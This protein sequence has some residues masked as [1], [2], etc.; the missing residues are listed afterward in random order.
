MKKVLIITYDFPPVGGI[1]SVYILRYVKLLPKLGWI[2]Y[3]LTTSVENRPCKV[4]DHSLLAKVP[5]EVHITRTNCTFFY[6]LFKKP[7]LSRVDYFFSRRIYFRLPDDWQIGWLPFGYSKGLD[8]IQ[9]EKIDIIF[10]FAHPYTAH[11]IA[12]LLKKR[13]NIRWIAHFVDEWT[14]NPVQELKNKCIKGVNEWMEKKVLTAADYILVAWPGMTSLFLKDVTYK[15]KVL[16][17]GFDIADFINTPEFDKDRFI[18]TYTGSFYGPQQPIHF[19]YAI[20]DLIEEGKIKIDKIQLDFFGLTR[21]SGFLKFEDT[22]LKKIIKRHSYVSHKEIINYIMTANLLLLILGSKR[23]SYTIPG[24]TFEYIAS[25]RPI[26]AL[27]P[28]KSDVANL[29]LKTKT[30]VIV[31]PENVEEIKRAILYYYKKWEGDRLNVEPDWGEIY[32]YE[33]KVGAKKLS[34]IFEKVLKNANNQDN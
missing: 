4:M 8:L 3:V 19:L 11:F 32:K 10:S 24:K 14:Q 31:D 5:K 15:S 26:L 22:L 13:T 30:G 20:K 2:P 18:I 29:V 21:Q 25:G 16:A 34:R 9:K 7:I 28:K 6:N 33:A 12:L 27:V 23:G 17:Y 1:D